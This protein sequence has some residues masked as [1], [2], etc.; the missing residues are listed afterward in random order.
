M[1]IES[2]GAA[3]LKAKNSGN[4]MIFASQILRQSLS[5]VSKIPMREIQ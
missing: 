3:R 1:Y 5:A 2:S 4:N